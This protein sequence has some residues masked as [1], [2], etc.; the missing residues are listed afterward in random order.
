MLMFRLFN[1]TISE[2]IGEQNIEELHRPYNYACSLGL[3]VADVNVYVFITG[4]SRFY[5][6][7]LLFLRMC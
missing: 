4:F 2:T 1:N 7:E 3:Y 6:N 5:A